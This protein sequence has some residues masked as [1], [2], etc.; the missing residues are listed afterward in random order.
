MYTNLAVGS[1][2]LGD[3]ST[4]KKEANTHRAYENYRS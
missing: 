3:A 2:L 4:N 1:Y